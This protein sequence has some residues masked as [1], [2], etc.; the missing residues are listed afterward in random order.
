MAKHSSRNGESF[1]W[2]S[3]QH[4]LHNRSQKLGKGVSI[5]TLELPYD[6]LCDGCNKLLETGTQLK[7]EKRMVGNYLSTPIWSFRTRCCE[8]RHWIEFHHNPEGIGYLVT[9]G[10]RKMIVPEPV[11]DR[12]SPKKQ[13]IETDDHVA[14]IKLLNDRQWKNADDA[15]AQLRK[16]FR[17]A[18]KERK[19]TRGESEVIRSVVGIPAS[20]NSSEKWGLNETATGLCGIDHT[21]TVRKRIRTVPPRKPLP[22]QDRVWHIRPKDADPFTS[23]A[24]LSQFTDKTLADYGI[25]KKKNTDQSETQ[26]TRGMA[27]YIH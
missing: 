25:R 4:S 26:W 12:G 13:K 23:N 27:S 24:P 15:N 8:C 9:R 17:A 19:Q 5:T 21:S 22:I 20:S 16:V 3:R 18:K 7:T 6:I 11:I 10:A 2:A 14:A 1:D